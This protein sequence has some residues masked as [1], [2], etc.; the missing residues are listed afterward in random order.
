MRKEPPQPPRE[1]RIKSLQTQ[2]KIR[3][4]SPTTPSPIPKPQSSTHPHSYS[5][6]PTLSLKTKHKKQK[7]HALTS[8][9]TCERAIILPVWSVLSY[10]DSLQKKKP[11]M[12][13]R[14]DSTENVSTLIQGTRW[15]KPILRIGSWI[16]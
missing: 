1:P 5:P 9:L 6:Y 12:L 14:N 11:T 7:T 10:F 8:I 2:L 3:S 15:L 4:Q 13:A 16:S